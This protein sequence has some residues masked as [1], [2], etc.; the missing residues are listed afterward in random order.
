MTPLDILFS[1]DEKGR[2]PL[3]RMSAENQL[4]IQKM[5]EKAGGKRNRLSSKELFKGKYINDTAPKKDA[6]ETVVDWSKLQDRSGVT[7]L[8]NTDKP[9][10]GSA[11]RAY[12]NEQIEVLAQ[13]KDGYVVRVKQW[14]ENGTPRW[15]LGFMEG[16]V[17]KSD[18]PLEDWSDA[19]FSHNDGLSTIWYENGQ[20]E[21]EQNFKDGKLMSAEVW[22]PNGEKCPVTNIDKDGNGLL[23]VWFENGQKAEEQNFKDGKPDGLSTIWYDNGQKKGEGNFKDGKPN[24]LSTIWYDNGQKE[25]EENW[26]DGKRDGLWIKWYENRQK[27]WEVTFKDDKLMS[28]VAWK[29]NGEKCPVTNVKDGNGVTGI[30]YENGQKMSEGNWKDGKLDGLSIFYNEDGTEDYRVTYKDGELVPR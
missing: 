24:G 28:V 1:P 21:R 9:F 23:T 16:K 10:S 8:P 5:L 17:A 20:K 26:K 13:F 12:E 15:D 18:V 14:Q 6:I 4:E 7:Y 27:E 30:Y 2:A 3:E 11:K 25:R 19:N 22:K 29:P